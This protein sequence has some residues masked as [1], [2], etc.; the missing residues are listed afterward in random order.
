M[1]GDLQHGREGLTG[2]RPTG[3]IGMHALRIGDDVG[4]H[5]ILF[6]A[7]GETLELV[8]KG[9]TRDSYAKGALE[10]AKFLAGKPPGRY[11]MGDVLGIA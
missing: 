1:G 3:Q 5:A 9:H 7:L 10:A 8:H 11:T 2:E 4:Q 6:G